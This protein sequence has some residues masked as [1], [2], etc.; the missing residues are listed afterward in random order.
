VESGVVPEGLDTLAGRTRKMTAGLRRLAGVCWH[1]AGR[2]TGGSF[3]LNRDRAAALFGVSTGTLS[4]W[5]AALMKAG[6]IVRVRLGSNRTRLNSVY[7]W[8]GPRGTA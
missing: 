3:N 2:T 4:G 7:R 8:H 5:L 6:V 1:M